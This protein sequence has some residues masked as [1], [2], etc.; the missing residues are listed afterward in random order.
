MDA[1]KIDRSFIGQMEDT[2]EALAVVR[3]ILNLGH[4]LNLSVIAEGVETKAQVE[5]LRGLGCR[6]A[7]GNYLSAPADA[8][9]I[10]VWLERGIDAAVTPAAPMVR[11]RV[12]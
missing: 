10:T 3:S 6:L 4:S 1:L 2:G 11:P 7:Q 12:D 5:R 8:E 9:A